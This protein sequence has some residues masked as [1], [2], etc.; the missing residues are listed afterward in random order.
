MSSV[1]GETA[2]RPRSRTI[3]APIVR[4]TNAYTCVEFGPPLASGI[5][6]TRGLAH[7]SAETRGNNIGSRPPDGGSFFTQQDAGPIGEATLL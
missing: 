4:D 7:R 5:V 2:E 1:V 6:P 3:K